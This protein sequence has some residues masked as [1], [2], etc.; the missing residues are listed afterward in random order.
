MIL[1]PGVLASVQDDSLLCPKRKACGETLDEL[2]HTIRRVD[3][4]RN[5]GYYGSGASETDVADTSFQVG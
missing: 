1:D 4:R 5:H 3:V 2:S